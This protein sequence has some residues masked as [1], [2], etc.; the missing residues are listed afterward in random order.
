MKLVSPKK[1][2]SPKSKK[3]TLILIGPTYSGFIEY[4]SIEEK[5][6]ELY[7]E[8][9]E[10]DEFAD[11]FNVVQDHRWLL[12]LAELASRIE[13]SMDEVDEDANLEVKIGKAETILIDFFKPESIH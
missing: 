11:E 7:P 3:M 1:A 8:L 10:S 12:E 6:G 2:E 9:A 13:L 5:I 4:D